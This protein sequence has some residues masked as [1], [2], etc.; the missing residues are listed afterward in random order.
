MARLRSARAAIRRLSASRVSPPVAD[1][2]PAKEPPADLP[3]TPS[4]TKPE[5]PPARPDSP[6]E[7]FAPAWKTVGIG[8]TISFSVAAIGTLAMGRFVVRS[9]VV[10]PTPGLVLL[11]LFGAVVN[12]AMNAQ[13]V[14][15]ATPVTVHPATPA[16]PPPPVPAARPGTP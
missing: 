9:A 5:P 14:H 10:D 15:A 16:A 3:P 12:A 4:E 11:H 1:T 8:Q 13:P 7:F 6:P 2:H